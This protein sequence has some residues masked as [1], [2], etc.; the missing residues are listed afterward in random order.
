VVGTG[1]KVIPPA[2]LTFMARRARAHITD[3]NAG[4]LSLISKAG[5]VARVIVK[6]AWATS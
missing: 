5:A 3:V 2:L 6:A 1:D 4:H